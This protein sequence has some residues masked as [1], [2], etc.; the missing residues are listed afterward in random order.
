MKSSCNDVVKGMGS[1]VKVQVKSQSHMMSRKVIPKGVDVAKK[2]KVMP[3]LA[4]R[5]SIHRSI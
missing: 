4:S 2:S 1:N 3:Y 5:S